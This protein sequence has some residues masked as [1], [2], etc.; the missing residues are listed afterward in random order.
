MEFHIDLYTYGK[1]PAEDFWPREILCLCSYWS[2][3]TTV[4]CRNSYM[5]HDMYLVCECVCQ[6][7]DSSL[8]LFSLRLSSLRRRTQRHTD[9]GT[10]PEH[11]IRLI[12]QQIS[13]ARASTAA[14][15]ITCTHTLTRTCT[16]IHSRSLAV[17]RGEHTETEQRCRRFHTH[18]RVAKGAV[19]LPLRRSIRGYGAFEIVGILR[20]RV[21]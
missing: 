12:R 15:A 1:Q 3:C 2:T 19:L 21:S 10:R 11:Q 17:L 14:R 6:A 5:H 4:V 18:H 7:V 13:L 20:Y 8:S 16:G 9:H